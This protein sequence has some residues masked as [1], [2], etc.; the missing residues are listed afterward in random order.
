MMSSIIAGYFACRLAGL[1][2]KV[3]Y[4]IGHDA[5]ALAVFTGLS[6]YDGGVQGQQVGALGDVV[7]NADDGVD[8]A[9]VLTELH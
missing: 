2:G 7:D 4:F 5:E 6:C 3:S 9:A 8:A 1:K